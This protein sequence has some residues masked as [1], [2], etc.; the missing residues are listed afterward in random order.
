MKVVVFH[1]GYGCETGCCGH[2]IE[3]DGEEISG[4]FVFDHPYNPQAEWRE[5][6]EEFITAHFGKDHGHDLDWEHCVIVDD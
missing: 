3:V 5:W 2:A 1:R 4:S 6:A